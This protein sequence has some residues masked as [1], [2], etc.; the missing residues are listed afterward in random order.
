MTRNTVSSEQILAFVESRPATIVAELVMRFDMSREA[1]TKQ[2]ERLHAARFIGKPR[3]GVY[4]PR[5][6]ADAFDGM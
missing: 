1:A 4:T 6:L 3:R 5:V 2:L